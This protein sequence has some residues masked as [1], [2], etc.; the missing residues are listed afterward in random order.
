MERELGASEAGRALRSRLARAREE[1]APAGFIQLEFPGRRPT[2]RDASAFLGRWEL[3]DAA[4]AHQIEV[5]AS[6]DTIVVH[7]RIRAPIGEF[8][9]SDD[10]VIQVT[11]EGTLEWG[12]TWFR[13]LAALLVLRGRILEDGTMEVTRE[14]RGWVP[15][16]PG[17]DLT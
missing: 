4:N 16:G 7:D 11:A 15:V 6:G 3:V 1:P 9:E 10:P 14:V 5:H 8:L 12:L 13:G 2:P 17:P